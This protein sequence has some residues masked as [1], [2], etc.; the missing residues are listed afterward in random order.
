MNSVPVHLLSEDRTEYEQI[1]AETIRAAPQHPDLAAIGERLSPEQLRTMALNATA[2]ITAAAATEYQY[3]VKVRED[4]RQ[5]P[6]PHRPQ[7]PT[8]GRAPTQPRIADRPNITDRRAP[9]V[10]R[11]LAAALLGADQAGGHRISDSTTPQQWTR[12]PYSRR[13]L[14][15]LLGLRVRPAAPMKTPAPPQTPKRQ[16]AG[17]SM[18]S[19]DTPRPD[20]ADTDAAHGCAVSPLLAS[21]FSGTATTV[22]LLISLAL[23]VITTESAL[24]RTALTAG[25]VCGAVTLALTV[26][27]AID[28][29]RTALRD[30]A[31][32]TAEAARYHELRQEVM[33]AKEAWRNSL[34][35]HGIM[36]FLRA[37]LA[38]PATHSTRPS[39]SAPP[40][41]RIPHLGYGRPTGLGD[42]P[43]PAPT[44]RPK[45]TSPDYSSPDFTG[46]EHQPE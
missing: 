45:Y 33:R 16:T 7:R 39:A 41:G 14:A 5:A 21:I 35:E 11:R 4:L 38:S 2:I 3:Y 23:N 9:T 37:A 28:R 17:T 10:G 31:R 34:R 40:A 22:L 13:L 42:G 43:D 36:P 44:P 19:R 32:T 20:S 24:A 12:L 26:A 30:R 6:P 1:L 29:Q 27:G 8:A 15:A 46:P 25:W 18:S